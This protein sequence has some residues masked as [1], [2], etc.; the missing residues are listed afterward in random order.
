[1]LAYGMT[2]NFVDDYV[3]F[4]ENRESKKNVKAIVKIFGKVCTRVMFMK[5]LLYQKQQFQK[6]CGFDIL[7]LDYRA[8]NDINVLDRSPMFKDLTE[9][10]GPK[11]RYII[12]I[13]KYNMGY[14][15]VDGIYPSWPTFIKTISKPQG[16]KKKNI[17]Q[18]HKNL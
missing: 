5:Q 1:M 7:F 17:L 6:T 11:V 15:L 18:M 4:G 14:Y 10:R 8:L 9:G 12:N 13:Y 16:N 3:R 2:T